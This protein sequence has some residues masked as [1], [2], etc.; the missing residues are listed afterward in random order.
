MREKQKRSLAVRGSSNVGTGHWALA[1][2]GCGGQ[3]SQEPFPVSR[4]WRCRP[5]VWRFQPLEARSEARHGYFPQPGGFQDLGQSRATSAAPD[6]SAR[7]GLLLRRLHLALQVFGVGIDLL[8]DQLVGS[9]GGAL[10]LLF[11]LRLAEHDYGGAAPLELLA[12][13]LEVIARDA[14]F[15]MPDQSA[16]GGADD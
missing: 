8:L 6:G 7:A 11:D 5:C 2:G 16:G 10:E 15:E 1:L 9:L 14:A 4:I 12:E 13:L 3:G